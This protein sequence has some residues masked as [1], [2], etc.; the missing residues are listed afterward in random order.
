[1]CEIKVWLQFFQ[2]GDGLRVL[3]VPERV[4][5]LQKPRVALQ[6]AAHGRDEQLFPAAGVD[7]VLRQVVLA[8]KRAQGADVLVRLGL[9]GPNPLPDQHVAVATQRV[10]HVPSLAVVVVP[11]SSSQ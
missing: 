11:D 4:A 6:A 1:M 8:R 5:Q 2:R 9:S 3:A 7:V 10:Q